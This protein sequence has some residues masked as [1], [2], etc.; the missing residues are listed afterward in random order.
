[1]K[2]SR[3]RFINSFFLRI[4]APLQ[5]F[6]TQGR[7]PEMEIRYETEKR[8]DSFNGRK[9]KAAA[10]MVGNLYTVIFLPDPLW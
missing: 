4:K 7:E 10:S 9:R 8:H 6:V 1:M 3:A 5:R 2:P